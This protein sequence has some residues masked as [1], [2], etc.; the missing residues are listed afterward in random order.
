MKLP[1]NRTNH[2]Q[3][4]LKRVTLVVLLISFLIALSSFL[5]TIYSEKLYTLSFSLQSDDIAFFIE[6]IKGTLMLLQI[7]S[8]FGAAI[9]LYIAYKTFILRTESSA[10]SSHI[11]Y[12]ELFK[13]YI[14]DEVEKVTDIKPSKI[15]VFVWYRLIHP[16]SIRGDISVDK[17]YE[18]LINSIV[19]AIEETNKS[20][21][22]TAKS[23]NY[24]S[25]QRRMVDS[26]SKLG[27]SM[28]TN[29]KNQFIETEENVFKLIDMVNQTFMATEIK[30]SKVAR[31][32]I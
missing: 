23:Y 1:K 29:T 17:N 26:L 31:K 4:W 24:N 2:N 14:H 18:T 20:L 15:D 25:H 12:F 16:N 27:I 22:P 19:E 8:A 3:V 6:K 7:I 10:L 30:L 28:D 9:G 21:S 32:Y 13:K 11:A 5:I